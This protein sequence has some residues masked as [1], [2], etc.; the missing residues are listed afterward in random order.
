MGL[1]FVKMKWN[2][3][4]QTKKWDTGKVN[5]ILY[6]C[7]LQGFKIKR[8]IQLSLTLETFKLLTNLLV[9]V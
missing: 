8:S 2:Q 4:K 5:A 6:T 1:G 3:K 9:L 7:I